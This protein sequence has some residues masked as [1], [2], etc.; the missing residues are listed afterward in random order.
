MT[1][2]WA[3]PFLLLAFCLAFVLPLGSHGLWIPDESRYAQIGQEMLLSGDWISPHFMGLRYFEKPIAGYWLIAI[4]QAV[5]GENLFGVRIASA[6]SVGLSGLLTYLVARRLWNDPRKSFICTLLFLSF[7]LVAAQGGYANLDPQFTLWVNLSLVA[8]WFAINTSGR[9]RLL[10]WALLGFACA[11]GFMTKGFLALLLPALIALPYMLWQRRLGEL[12]KF[13][14]LAVIVAILVCLP[15]ALAVQHHEPDFW[16]FFFW[17]EHIRRFAGEDAQHSQPWWFYLPVLALAS[18]PW[19]GLLPTTLKQA[20]QTRYQAKTGFVLLWLLLPLAFF[21]LSR[22]KLPTYILPCMLPLALLM[23]CALADRLDQAKVSAIR[24]NGV[25][26]LLL[27][28]VG[29][30]ALI[31]LQWKRPVYDNEPLHLA[32]LVIGLSGWIVTNILQALKPLSWWASSAVGAWLVVALLPASLP[33]RLVFNKTPDLFIA[34]HAQELT[35]AKTLLSNDLGAASAL[36][37]RIRRPDVAL[38]NTVGELKYGL[39]YPEAASRIVLEK[40]VQQWM[41]NARRQGPVGVVLRVNSDDDRREV[42]LLPQDAIRYEEGN[43]VILIFA[44][45]Q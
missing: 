20:W 9:D 34:R 45:A 13:G 27:G 41:L 6:L 29:M 2:R 4:G 17:H 28:L 10:H 39:N 31:Y 5:F 3:L 18:L 40:D 21:S 22:G 16:S 38:Y 26:N 36:A 43:I 32:L 24:L 12:F 19:A 44:R 23:G 1:V 42:A 11:M 14:P 35:Q 30:A 8:L 15:W 37:W 25:L 7:A 33:N